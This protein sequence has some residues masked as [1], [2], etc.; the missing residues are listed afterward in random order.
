MSIA[1]QAGVIEKH[2]EQATAALRS[3]RYFEAE[4]AADKA[5]KLAHDQCDFQRMER[6][7]DHLAEA[8]YRRLELALNVGTITI[9]DTLPEEEIAIEAGCY[10]VQ[11]PLVGAHA[12]RLR[13]A[14]L[15]SEIPV[16]VLCREPSTML[17]LWP[18]VAI[19]GS[20]TIRT[21]IDPPLDPDNPDLDWFIEAL[22][23]LGDSA[24]ESLDPKATAVRR[25][26][27]LLTRLDALPEHEGLHRCLQDACREAADERSD[28][29]EPAAKPDSRS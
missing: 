11:P 6:I 17:G 1:F 28:N 3:A 27:A 23:L 10:L 13:V 20:T 16:A 12:R 21:K 8:R 25:I 7:I 2:I 5:L 14:A 24:I 22:G 18:I 15:D 4:R 9:V 29:D 26:D 19:T